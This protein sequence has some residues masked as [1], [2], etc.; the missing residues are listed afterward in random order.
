MA[1]TAEIAARAVGQ[2]PLSIATSLALEGAMGI[3][4]EHPTNKPPIREFRELWV[5][6][7]TVFRNFMGALSKD[8]ARAADEHDVAEAI[9][10]ELDTIAS[11]VGEATNGSVRCVFYIS[12]YKGLERKYRYA[13]VRSD[14]T[15]GQRAYTQMQ[16]NVLQT[17]IKQHADGI[18]GFDLELRPTTKSK[19][20]ILTHYPYD[21]L[22]RHAFGELVL[23]ESHTG[24]LKDFTQWSSKYLNGNE[25]AQ[26]PFTSYFMQLFGDK[27]TFKPQ[28]S[29]W[30]NDIKELA[31]KYNWGPTTSRDKI[32]YGL[33]QLAD[34]YTRDV[35][36][37]MVREK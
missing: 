23:L 26:I 17:L 24:K 12:N 15:D 35:I 27:E 1:F 31:K 8:H 29:K 10:V 32:M 30:R 19:T 2:Y 20:L 22:S 34:K 11:I 21:L 3:H 4:E 5:N 36:L 6:V 28:T 7:R 37:E 33:D 13:L 18:V 25:L 14:T 16:N 9:S